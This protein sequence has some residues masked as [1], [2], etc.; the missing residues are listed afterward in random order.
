MS[1]EMSPSELEKFQLVLGGHVYFQTLAAAVESDLFTL[2]GGEGPMSCEKIAQHLGISDKPTRILLLGL[3][4]LG[5]LEKDG[6]RYG[7]SRSADAFLTAE[8]P[9]SL[10]PLSPGKT[11]LT[12]G[13]WLSLRQSLVENRNV[14]LREIA[15]QEETLYERPRHHPEL[16]QIFQDAMRA[17]SVNAGAVLV[18]H[19][20]LSGVRHLVDVGGGDVTNIIALARNYPELRE[21][22]FDSPSVC[23]IA[24]QNIANA[25]HGACERSPGI[26]STT[27][28]LLSRLPAVRALLDDLR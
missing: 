7:N 21:T 15:G 27:S 18:A 2:V 12:P 13:R 19:V 23:E 10:T 5:L 6:V 11:V 3:T 4:A 28:P 1:S 25:R 26:V 16:E 17:V 20:D 14:G 24:C 22:V 8:R 9:A